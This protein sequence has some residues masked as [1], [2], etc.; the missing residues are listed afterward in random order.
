[1]S[2]P[3]FAFGCE[4]R[5]GKDTAC[6]YMMSKMRLECKR[7]SFAAALYDILYFA[8][9]QCNFPKT[10]DRKFLQWVGTE[11]ARAQN[12][13]V[14]VDIVK[15]KIL[16]LPEDMPIFVT[17]VRFP[18]EAKTLSELNFIL[19]KIERDR[20]LEDISHISETALQDY[21]WDFVIQN[22]GD[23]HEFYA[24]LD[25][26]MHSLDFDCFKR[27]PCS[28]QNFKQILDADMNFYIDPLDTDPIKE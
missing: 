14:W 12:P 16:E 13:D 20:Q 3:R 22:N 10:K 15:T 28:T 2:F 24:K 19:I 5:V 17:D 6:D 11:W 7:F 27:D 23:I 21:R 8:Q 26:L 1:M 9:S 25:N 18:N 4:A